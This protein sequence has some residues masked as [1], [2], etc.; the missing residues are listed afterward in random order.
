MTKTANQAMLLGNGGPRG[1]GDPA[2]SSITSADSE[3]FKKCSRFQRC[4]ANVCPLDTQMAEKETLPGEE[5]C[6][7]PKTRRMALAAPY[8]ELLPWRGLWARELASLQRWEALPEAERAARI[9]AGKARLLA[10]RLRK[11]SVANENPGL[12]VDSGAT[13]EK[14]AEAMSSALGSQSRGENGGKAA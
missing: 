2:G 6:T 11:G 7:L 1:T 4:S 8:P 12:V 10:A 14:M 9:E 13:S 3:P 5:A